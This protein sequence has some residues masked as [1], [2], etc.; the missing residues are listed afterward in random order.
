[1]SEARLMIVED[2]VIVAEDLSRSLRACGYDVAGCAGSADEAI[3][4]ARSVMP[5]LILMD[6]VLK[7]DVSG[8]AAAQMI[9]ESMDV[10]IVFITGHSSESL[11]DAAVQAGADGYVV[12]PF[13][14]RQVMAAIKVALHRRNTRRIADADGSAPRLLESDKLSTALSITPREREIINGLVSYRRLSTVADLLG[15]S[16]HTARNHLKSIFRKLG[17]HSQDELVQYV[18]D[19]EEA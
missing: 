10:P 17:L 7:G 3:H 11:I 14:L 9:I 16:V 5:D 18:L 19:G 13:Q 8:I 2:E 4:M 12:K 15:I 6:V 1:M